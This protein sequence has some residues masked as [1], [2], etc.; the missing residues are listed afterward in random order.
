MDEEVCV[1]QRSPNT[2]TLARLKARFRSEASSNAT[3]G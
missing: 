2:T 1:A 3:V